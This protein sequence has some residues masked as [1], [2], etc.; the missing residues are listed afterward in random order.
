MNKTATA[1]QQKRKQKTDYYQI[2]TNR[3]IALLDKGVPP[4]RKTWGSHGLARN[5]A[6][7][8]VYTGIN[9]LMLNFVAP[10]DIPLYMSRKQIHD[11]GGHIIKGS[12]AEWVYFYGDYYKDENGKVI[13]S[14]Q[15]VTREKAGEELNHI[16]FLK[17]RPVYNISCV[18]G[19]EIVNPEM[20][21]YE[22]GPIEECEVLLAE[23]P[24]K[25]TYVTTDGDRA[26]YDPIADRITIPNMKYFTASEE[27]YC[28]LFHELVHWSGHA[29][30]LARP[31]VMDEKA[32]FGKKLYAE[33]ELI[34]EMGASYLCAIT[35]IDREAVT[36]NSAAYIQ[37]WIKRL[38]EDK[39]LI[40]RVAAKAQQ[41]IDFLTKKED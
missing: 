41:A 4:W 8:H 9:M 2:V 24:I 26:F 17:A 23:I 27:Y 40:F 3:I 15:V 32:T 31:G 39:K 7:G 19:I 25:P 16:R 20:P 35:G 29:S 11:K 5:Y 30:R 14:N 12:K 34:A 13:P 18:E 33:E 38:Q 36:E 21:T 10:Y 37:G 22:Y 28:T 6:S 1:P